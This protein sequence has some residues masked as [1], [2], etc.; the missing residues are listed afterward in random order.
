MGKG[1]FTVS[2]CFLFIFKKCKSKLVNHASI[3]DKKK[4]RNFLCF[5]IPSLL[6]K[7]IKQILVHLLISAGLTEKKARNFYLHI[8]Q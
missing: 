2:V 4:H 8:F 6:L 3:I 7:Q 1:V 5:L